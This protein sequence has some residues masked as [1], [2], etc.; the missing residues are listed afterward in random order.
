MAVF[1]R[2]VTID[3]YVHKLD[4][5]WELHQLLKSDGYRPGLDINDEF[6]WFLSR[7]VPSS[8]KEWRLAW[9]LQD[10]SF[11]FHCQRGCSLLHITVYLRMFAVMNWLLKIGL[12]P[13][14]Q[15]YYLKTP[16]LIASM[17]FGG[18]ESS[19]RILLTQG[20]N[21]NIPDLDGNISLHHARN[22]NAV[23]FLVD[24][25]SNVNQQNNI[26]ITPLHHA[27]YGCYQSKSAIIFSSVDL[28]LTPFPNGDGILDFVS[29]KGYVNYVT[30]ILQKEFGSYIT[31]R[32]PLKE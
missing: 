4:K 24:Y 27:L 9:R 32:Q 8:I 2:H 17:I 15:D 31:D 12:K 10:S 5:C 30:I 7:I 1:G 25:K 6:I 16:L 21:P 18:C 26:G 14:I 19:I 20:A 22:Y 3:D 29:R 11:L 28:I 23:R 13:D